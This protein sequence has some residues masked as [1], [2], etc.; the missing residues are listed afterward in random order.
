MNIMTKTLAVAL[1]LVLTAA[2]LW[3]AAADEEPAAAAKKEMVLDPTTGE[4]VEA[5]RYGGTLTYPRLSDTAA[6]WA[7]GTVE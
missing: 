5:P 7:T 1:V 6:D 2:G 4:M 3:A